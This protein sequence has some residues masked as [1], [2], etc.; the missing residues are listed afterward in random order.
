MLH[1]HVNGLVQCGA[2]VGVDGA[3][4]RQAGDACKEVVEKVGSLDQMPQTS[5]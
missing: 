2:G 3:D 4:K 5:D 1:D